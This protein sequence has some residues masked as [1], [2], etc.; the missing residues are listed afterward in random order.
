MAKWTHSVEEI[1]RAIELARSLGSIADAAK[2]SG[3]VRETLQY[4]V[5]KSRRAALAGAV[6]GPPIPAAAV[7]PVGFVV[8]SNSSTFDADGNLKSQSIK[9]VR[10]AGEVYEPAAGHVVKGESVLVDADGRVTQRWVKTALASA[11]QIDGFRAAFAAYDGASVL[12][13]APFVTDDDLLTVYPLA[14]LHVGLYSWGAECG[15]DYDVD[16][17]TDLVRRNINSLVAKSEPSGRH[18]RIRRSVPPER[19]KERNAAVGASAGRRR[20]M[21]ARFRGRRKDADASCRHSFTET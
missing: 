5:N 20:E 16:I 3:M 13:D 21:A 9:H 4:H 17:A 8:A 12:R 1:D 2:Q 11:D 14:D 7:P 6:G 10:D 19:P 15:A 18:P